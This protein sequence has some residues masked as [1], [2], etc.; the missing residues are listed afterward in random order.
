MRIIATIL[1]LLAIPVYAGTPSRTETPE[2]SHTPTPRSCEACLDRGR[3]KV[4][5]TGPCKP[6]RCGRVDTATGRREL[7]SC[8][9][10]PWEAVCGHGK[11]VEVLR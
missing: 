1:I 7:M 2:P 10:C 6:F 11:P 9:D 3:V 8:P 4:T 5:R